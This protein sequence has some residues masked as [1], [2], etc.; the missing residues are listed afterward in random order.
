MIETFIS[1]WYNEFIKSVLNGRTKMIIREA[2]ENES[3]TTTKGGGLK[4]EPLKAVKP[5]G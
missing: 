2:K 3:L 1:E 5:C 4:C